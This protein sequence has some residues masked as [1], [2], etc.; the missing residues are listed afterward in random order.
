MKH[1]LIALATLAL[2]AAPAVAGPVYLPAAVNEVDGAY[3]RMTD[4]WVTNPDAAIQGFVV[5]YLP[6]TSNGTTRVAGDEQGPFYLAPGESKRYSD[7][8]PRGFR[9]LLELDGSVVLQFSGALTV[10]NVNGT[11]VSESEVPVLDQT[12]LVGAGKVVALQGLERAGALVTTN[13]GVV[14]LAHSAAHCTITIRHKNG[15]LAIQNVPVDLPPVSSIQFDDALGLIGLTLATEGARAE[16]SCN[17]SFWAYVSTYNDQTGEAEFIEG[18]ATIAG[19]TLTEPVISDPDPDPNPNPPPGNATV[20]TRNGEIVR[21]P[22]SN[23]GTHNYRVNMPFGG[24]RTFKKLVV[25]FDF[26]VGGWDRSNSSGFHCVMWLNNGQSWANLFGYVNLR[27][28]RSMTVFQVNATGGGWQETNQGGSPQP[29][30]DY[31]MHYE[32]DLNEDTVFY[33]ITHAGGGTVSTKAYN[34]RGST[35]STSSFFI[36]F[37]YQRAEGPESYTPGWTF[38]DLRA[39][40][41]P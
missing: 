40:F 39:S 32:Y 6:E 24:N 2:A 5:R 23:N 31:H 18:S 34:L 9:G 33:R 15:L 7:L 11:K 27:G 8:I 30:G 1:T 36:E 28:T 20:F 35:F 4:L 25:D 13:L 38:S 17:Q 41:I 19:S 22:T 26:H 3:T 10:R 21:Y 14:N 29:G 12:E 37:G 16:V